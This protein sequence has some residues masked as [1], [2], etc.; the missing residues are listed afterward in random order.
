MD[1]VTEIRRFVVET[2]MFGQS[3]S[4][5][6]DTSFMDGGI[7]DSTG[8]LE[9]IGF[10]EQ[11]FG[12]QIPAEDVVPANLDSLNRIDGYLARK[13]GRGPR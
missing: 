1:Y 11:R 8:V 7:I 10:L 3:D 6:G 4:L 9:L 13:L 2:F 5:D 12:I